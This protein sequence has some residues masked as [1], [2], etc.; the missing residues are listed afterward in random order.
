MAG[1]K[2]GFI[3][4]ADVI[5]TVEKLP[6]DLDWQWDERFHK[7]FLY[8][9]QV[10]KYHN[11]L[12]ELR[13]NKQISHD[14][15]RVYNA[16]I[17]LGRK[18]YKEFQEKLRNQPR[19]DAQKFIGEK[20]TRNYIFNKYGKI[21]LRCGSLEK[22]T[23]DHIIPIYLNGTNVLDNLQPLCSSCNLWKGIKIIDFR[24]NGKT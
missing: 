17:Y 11:R 3:L 18:R 1:G 19:V 21:C 16:L 20:K 2:K 6:I 15:R 13:R 23:I 24:N 10:N 12:S 5:H 8:P 14:L 22:I 4:Y 7:C 9:K